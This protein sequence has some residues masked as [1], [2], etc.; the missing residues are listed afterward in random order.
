MSELRHEEACVKRY[1]N[2]ALWALYQEQPDGQWMTYLTI[3][4][5][6]A[7]AQQA[8]EEYIV[9]PALTLSGATLDDCRNAVQHRGHKTIMVELLQG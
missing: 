8:L 5:P 7:T 4:E 2:C 3:T 9:V 1:R 6:A